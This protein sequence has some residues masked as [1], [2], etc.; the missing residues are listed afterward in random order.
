M[1]LGLSP[2]LVFCDI[3]QIDIFKYRGLTVY[4][5]RTYDIK[6]IMGLITDIGKIV[7]REKEAGNMVDE[8]KTRIQKVEEK[9][10]EAKKKPLVYFEQNSIGRT[11]AKGSLTHE[12]ITRAGG[13]NIA[14]DQPV[15]FPI[16]SQEFIIEKNPDVIIVEEWGTQP[17]EVKGRDGWKNINAVKSNRIFKSKSYYTGYTPR[18]LDGLE[19]YAKYFYPELL[20]K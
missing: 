2:D 14:Q 13:I 3:G 8:M 20:D 12:L 18:C 19:E 10:K 15:A 5:T 9:V 11:R 7:G 17:S 6:G 16:L 4:G 1:I